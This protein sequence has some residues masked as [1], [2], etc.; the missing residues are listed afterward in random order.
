M[1]RLLLVRHGEVHR[2]WRGCCYGRADV[3]LSPSG[4]AQSRRLVDQL[5]SEMDGTSEPHPRRLMSSGL[6]RAH[7]LA[8]RLADRLGSPLVVVPA[9]QERHFGD[10][11][12]RSWQE[13]YD[14]TGNAMDGMIEDPEC[15]A[16]RGGET[17]FQLRDRVWAWYERLPPSGLT[18]AVT[19]GG[20]IAALRGMLSD[21]PVTAWPALVPPYG[22]VT[23]LDLRTP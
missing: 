10:W 21:Q 2:R 19:H 1:S 15:W 7:Y 22:S 6:R 9:L 14:A 8:L 18:V 23:E 3:G 5:A 13:I 17:T 11:E 4:M 12:R 20:P 16:P